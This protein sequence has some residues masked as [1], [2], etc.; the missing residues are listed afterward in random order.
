MLDAPQ[1]KQ[2][3]QVPEGL[4]LRPARRFDVLVMSRMVR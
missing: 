4:G 1:P 2:L 3:G